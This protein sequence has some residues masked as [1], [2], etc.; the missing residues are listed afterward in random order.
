M[1]ASILTM[2]SFTPM[3]P[4]DDTSTSDAEHP[5]VRAVS[6]AMA[7][8]CARPS[9]PVQ[10]FAQPLFTT[11][12]R[13]RPPTFRKMLVRDE[14]RRRLGPVGREHRRGRGLTVGDDEREV[15][16]AGFL[17]PAGHTSGAESLRS[18]DGSQNAANVHRVHAGFDC[19]HA[20]IGSFSRSVATS[21]T[22]TG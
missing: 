1:P 4:V 15:R 17:D 12:A 11:T 10:A 18:T 13:A 2:S 3:T 8:A 20:G 19:A 5:T 14:H 22:G 21:R 9:T 16:C 7:R 6:S